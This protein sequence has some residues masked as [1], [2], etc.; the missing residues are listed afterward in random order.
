[1]NKD[2]KDYIEKQQSPQKEILKK[3]R[4]IILKT[5]PDCGEKMAWGVPVFAGGKFYIAA[6]KTRVHMGFA[7][8]GLS[9]EDMDQFEG[10]GKTM[11]H[12]KIPSLEDI[13][14]RKITRLIK[15]VDKKVICEPC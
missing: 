7:V 12:I 1:M 4:R 8:S 14:E 6:M 2:I 15:L 5:L 13:D 9:K 11:R 10:R 3:L